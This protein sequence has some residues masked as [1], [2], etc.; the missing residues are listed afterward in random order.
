ML[1][2]DAKY[3]ELPTKLKDYLTYTPIEGMELSLTELNFLNKELKKVGKKMG[4]LLYQSTKDGNSVSNFHSRC[5]GHGA[6]VVIYKSVNG[7]MFGGYT[8]RSWSNP[9]SG[10][11]YT[12]SGCFLFRL[13]PSM[14]RY[15]VKSG[16]ED[17]AVYMQNTYGPTFGDGHDIYITDTCTSYANCY[18]HGSTYD[19]P[20][21]YELTGGDRY[22]RIKD[23]VVLLA[24]AL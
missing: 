22:F 2:D 18:S 9:I 10:S 6:T 14:E 1:L 24:T 11:Y 20:S 8:S 17:S 13:R 3:Y 16:R 5:D 7:N 19:I 15:D 21:S 4:G 23:Y 12:S